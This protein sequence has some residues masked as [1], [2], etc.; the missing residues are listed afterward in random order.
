MHLVNTDPPY[1]V[2]VEPRSNNAIA[3]GL[4]TKGNVPGAQ[5]KRAARHHQQFDLARHANKGVATGPMRAR[6]RVLDNDFLPEAEFEKLL[7]AWFTNLA[8]ALLPGR[9]FYLW[10]GYSNLKNYPAAIAAAGLYFSQS[11]V[12][13]KKWPVLTRKDFMG[14]HEQCFYG[15]KEGAAHYFNPAITNATDL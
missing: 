1:N 3:A 4:V 11:I 9:G 6:D 10:G 13:D 7:R 2:K 14:A 5:R 8:D 12:W 15:W